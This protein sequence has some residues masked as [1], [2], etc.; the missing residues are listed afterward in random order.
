MHFK[1]RGT[2]IICVTVRAT[3]STINVFLVSLV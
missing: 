3:A 2:K 1:A